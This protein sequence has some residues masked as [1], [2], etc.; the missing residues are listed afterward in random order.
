MDITDF[1]TEAISESEAFLAEFEVK[2]VDDIKAA[3]AKA[4]E[5]LGHN[6]RR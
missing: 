3:F 2:V 4:K 6:D 5:A 1:A